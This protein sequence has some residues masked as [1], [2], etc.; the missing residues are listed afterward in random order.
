MSTHNICSY[1]SAEALLTSTHNICSY[2]EIKQL[3]QNYHQI[4]L[5]NNFSSSPKVYYVTLWLIYYK[6]TWGQSSVYGPILH[7]LFFV[8]LINMPSKTMFF[9]V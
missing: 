7:F 8:L 2:G 4:L 9:P 5:H 1:F 6:D 3:S